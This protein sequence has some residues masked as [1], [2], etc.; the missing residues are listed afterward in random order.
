MPAK[1]HVFRI[2]RDVRF[3]RDPRPYKAHFS[4]A[5]SRGGK[6]GPFACYYVHCEPG[7]ADHAGGYNLGACFVGGGIWNPGSEV[8]GRLRRSLDERPERWRRVLVEDDQL[9][10]TFLAVAGRGKGKPPPTTTTTTTS[11][12]KAGDEQAIKAALAAMNAENA[13]KKK[14]LGY[15]ADHREIELLKLRNF[16]VQ[17]RIDEAL[18]SAPDGQ[19]QIAAML[20]ALVPFVAH[21][22]RTAMPDAGHDD[23]SD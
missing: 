12:P 22:N 23:D 3:S 21:L 13:L 9:R 15:A 2:Y 1:D 14:P 17:R 11:P 20:Q 18:F 10:A 8:L 7:V 16:T 19:A 4:A 5:W 6:T